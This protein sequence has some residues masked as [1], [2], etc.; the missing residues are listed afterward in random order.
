MISKGNRCILI[1]NDFPKNDLIKNMLHT[2]VIIKQKI[3]KEW[4]FIVFKRAEEFYSYNLY[5]DS[6]KSQLYFFMSTDMPLK[7]LIPIREFLLLYRECPV[8]SLQDTAIRK[9]YNEINNSNYIIFKNMT[10]NNFDSVGD[11]LDCIN[12][13]LLNEIRCKF[14]YLPIKPNQH[15]IR[16]KS[17]FVYMLNKFIKPFK[18]I[19]KVL[20]KYLLK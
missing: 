12:R 1:V 20:S 8:M 6:K 18:S 19:L 14:Y 16:Y 3:D 15:I 11:M 17:T 5:P 2:K 10:H 4:N 13:K 7:V 9:F